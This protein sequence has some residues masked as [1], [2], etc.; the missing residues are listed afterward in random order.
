MQDMIYLTDFHLIRPPFESSQQQTLDWLVLAHTEAERKENNCETH[1]QTFKES[2]HER[3]HRVG[4][5]P[6]K[7]ATRGHVID[8][9]HHLDWHRMK[10]PFSSLASRMKHFEEHADRIFQEF[11]ATENAPDDL[12]HTTCT[13]YLAPSAA[14]KLISHKNWTDTTVTH[15]YHMGCYASI[16][17]VRIAKGFLLSDSAK[18][19]ADVVHTEMCSLHVNPALHRLDA[20]V[21]QSLFADGFIKYSLKKEL[22]KTGFSVISHREEII[23]TS[24]GSMT[25]NLADWGF[26]MSLAKEVPVLIA[27]SLP[28]FVQQLGA[29]QDSLFAVH[30]GGPKILT[31]IQDILGLTPT[32]LQHSCDV[33]HKFG[34]MS[35]AT[36]PTIWQTIALD[37]NVPSGT[38][39]VSLAFGPG[40]T[41][42]GLLMKKL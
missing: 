23:P 37:P 21:S 15:A 26:E 29:S 12:I 13:G 1:L 5:K 35:S 27:R 20:L 11:Y 31:N 7:I 6:D 30:P 42:T 24:T 25:W 34:N 22:P 14:Q 10:I 32:Q 41:L 3:L 17:S 38:Q 19:R 4:C 8:D 39:I 2:I 18:K 40:L 16:P 28:R 33:L 36:L 9:Y